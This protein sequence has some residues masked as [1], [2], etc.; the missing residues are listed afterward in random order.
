MHSH[1]YRTPEPFNNEIVVVV[2]NSLN[3]QGISIELVEVAKKVNMSFRSHYKA[4][5]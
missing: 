4:Y 3:G 2:G 1:I 5:Q